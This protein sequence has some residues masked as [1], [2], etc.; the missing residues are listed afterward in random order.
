MSML[1]STSCKGKPNMRREH[2]GRVVNV[3]V[4]RGWTYIL[5]EAGSLTIQENF[6]AL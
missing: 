1:C 6:S 2:A 3:S 5:L 4:V